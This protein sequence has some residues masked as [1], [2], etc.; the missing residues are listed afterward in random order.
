MPVH[1]VKPGDVLVVRTSGW[2]G[3]LIRLGSFFR[4]QPSWWNHAAIAHH[5]DDAGT[6]WGIEGRPGGVGWKNIGKWLDDKHTLTT[7]ELWKAA[8]D[9]QRGTMCQGAEAMLGTSYDW[10]AIVMDA[11]QVIN[12]LWRERKDEWGD[13]VPGQ[14]V[15]TSYADYVA[16]QVGLPN[17]DADRFA[18][19]GDWAELILKDQVLP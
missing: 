10:P 12:P 6:Y 15:C 19:P 1:L 13:D 7:A 14:V 9:E 18:T 8:T 16:E 17:P 4:E 5:I 2:A 11:L 3:F